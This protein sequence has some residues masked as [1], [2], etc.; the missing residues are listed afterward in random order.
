[1]TFVVQSLDQPR[2]VHLAVHPSAWSSTP[3]DI[4]N[5]PNAQ[6]IPSHPQSQNI[7][8]LQLPPVTNIPPPIS[9][10][11]HPLA[12]VLLKHQNAL[13]ALI[14]E[15]VGHT[16]GISDL[17]ASRSLAVQAIELHGWTWPA[18]LDEEFPAA[19]EGG[20]KYERIIVKFVI[21]YPMCFRYVLTVY[22]SV[23]KASCLSYAPRS[24]RQRYRHMPSKS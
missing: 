8:E 16:P 13:Q 23:V 12:F 24:T 9:Q 18:I 6:P 17:G 19:T 11:T 14:H 20:V 10:A 5:L 1:M 15:T 7:P 3:P 21:M 22:N 4:P 2:V